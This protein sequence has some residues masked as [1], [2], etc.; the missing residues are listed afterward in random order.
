MATPIGA[1]RFNIDATMDLP[2]DGFSAET[3]GSA[4]F[5]EAVDG[6]AVELSAGYDDGGTPV[7][8]EQI[9]GK[10]DEWQLNVS[11]NAMTSTV[12]GRDKVG[13]LLDRPYRKIYIRA[14]LGGQAITVLGIAVEPPPP[15]VEPGVPFS[16]G[17]FLASEIAREIVVAAGLTLAWQCRNYELLTNFDA[18]GRSMDLL[19]QLVAPW[20]QTE[21]F[22]VD[23]F[24]QG[25][26]VI[27]RD[28]VLSPTVDYT[29][30][31]TDAR[32][33][34]MTVRKR[35]TSKI[36]TVKLLGKLVPPGLVFGL[37]ILSSS[38]REETRTVRTFDQAGRL[39]KTVTT[40]QTFRDPEG[41]EIKK[42]ETTYDGVAQTLTL[43]DTTDTTWEDVPYNESGATRQPRSLLQFRKLEGVVEADPG[44]LF[45]ETL[46][47]ETSWGWDDGQFLA[48]TTKKKF[49]FVSTGLHPT[50]G[51]LQGSLQ[52]TEERV[53][54]LRD[55]DHLRVEKC[56]SVYERSTAT[57]QLFLK[58]SESVISAGQRPGG[59]RPPRTAGAAPNS[60]GAPIELEQL[61]SAEPTAGDVVYS[62]PNMDA[63]DLAFIMGQFQQSSGIYEYEIN[64]ELASMPW[65]RKGNVLRITGL[66]AEDGVTPIPL[67][68]ALVFEQRLNFDE[69]SSSP[70]MTSSIRALF[71]KAT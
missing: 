22:K 3:D 51:F 17:T 4:P 1:M 44:K 40:V 28:R 31:V 68:P 24:A 57:G 65:V 14:P 70:R 34:R 21:R 38:E 67:D 54:T 11:P 63:D 60:G 33:L 9:T 16:I 59:V 42:V 20:S 29:F 58:T 5:R 53:E 49:E 69:S 55:V 41:V 27:C 37:D 64:I 23:V 47:E 2:A 30:S 15:E 66:L 71:W 12:G 46:R 18:S 32:I 25:N 10:V 61:I 19:R 6:D 52:Q 36:G 48:V 13:D 26:V 35:R 43:L 39:T 56:T 62:N 50:R 45:R 8:V 7:I